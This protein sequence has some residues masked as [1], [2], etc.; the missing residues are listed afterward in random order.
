MD[1]ILCFVIKT[2]QRHSGY[3]AL[4]SILLFQLENNYKN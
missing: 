1:F 3:S 2:E 4:K